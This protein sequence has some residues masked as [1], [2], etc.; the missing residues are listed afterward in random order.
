LVSAL[1]SYTSELN[2]TMLVGLTPK[3]RQGHFVAY[4]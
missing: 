4:E 1:M 3:H 2:A